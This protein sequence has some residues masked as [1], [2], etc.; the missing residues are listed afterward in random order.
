MN[1]N[2]TSADTKV[3]SS[4][5]DELLSSA[6]LAANPIL[7]LQFSKFSKQRKIQIQKEQR[8]E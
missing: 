3:D 1:N 2:V 5:K 4:T 7:C 8:A 6:P